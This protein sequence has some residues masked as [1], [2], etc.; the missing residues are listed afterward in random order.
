MSSDTFQNTA[1]IGSEDIYTYRE[2]NID[3]L[4]HEYEIIVSG[5]HIKQKV[6]SELQKIAQTAKLPGFRVG[7]TP[8][9]LV[10]KNYRN[11]ALE[12]T[13]ND[14]IDYCS[15]NLMQKIKVQ[16]HIYPKIDIVSLPNLDEKGEKSNLVY[17][18]SFESMPEVP[19]IDL[20]KI[21]LKEL[22][23]KIEED[24]VKEHINSISV[25]I[26][27]FV[28]V[29]DPSYQAKNGDKLTIDFEGRI[30][31]KLF[32]GGSSKNFSAKLG[33][34]AFISDF[35][36]QLI[37]MRTGETKNFELQF[38]EN[39]P[40]FAGQRVNF[41]VQV[42]DIQI[43]KEFTSDDDMAKAMGFGDYSALV[44]YTKKIISDQ[45]K[46][47]IDLLMR[48]QLFDCLDA[49]YNFDVPTNV[50]NQE[51]KR[52]KEETQDDQ[53]KSHKE[54]ERRVKLAMLLMKFSTE[55]KISV[56]HEDIFNV[57]LNQYVS[58]DTP[59]DKAMNYYRSE[60]RFQELVRGQALEYKVAGYMIEKVSKEQ[61]TVSVKE[62]KELFDNI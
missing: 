47:M 42:N 17:K 19:A 38:P 9:E 39:Y 61:Q 28:S 7:K 6:D 60:K 27:N 25:K 36:D 14:V 58:R 11:T 37:G 40:Q 3:K 15:E 32:K 53:D 2:L 57:I 46:E 59:L 51:Q 50:V 49:N 10:I 4:K 16:S 26:P 20:D 18:L 34:N 43:I 8:Y 56:S 12:S 31:G 5:E 52:V 33:S 29:N 35:E 24:D 21:N 62:L 54:A 44:D 45:C 55:H 41:F 13:L 30:R 22:E 1:I 23:V 48:K